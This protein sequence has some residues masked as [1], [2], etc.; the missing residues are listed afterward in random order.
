M[1]TATM[2]VLL[3]RGRFAHQSARAPSPPPA[4]MAFEAIP[5]DAGETPTYER[6]TYQY[7]GTEPNIGGN[8]LAIYRWEG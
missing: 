5:N 2:N 1:T 7:I 8:P 4:S 6:H 3:I